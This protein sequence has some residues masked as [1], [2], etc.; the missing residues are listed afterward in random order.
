VLDVIGRWT[1]HTKGG[2]VPCVT[3]TIVSVPAGAT[4]AAG[5]KGDTL[6]AVAAEVTH[7]K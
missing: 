5:G 1:R 6:A 7:T 4:L 2:L 3:G